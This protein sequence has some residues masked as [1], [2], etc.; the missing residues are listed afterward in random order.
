MTSTTLRKHYLCVL[1]TCVVFVALGV[2]LLVI[3]SLFGFLH[4]A[5]PVGQYF[6]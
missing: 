1:T 6:R 2:V 5:S 3:I 4:I